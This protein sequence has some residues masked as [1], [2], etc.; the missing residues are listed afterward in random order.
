[1]LSDYHIIR[2]VGS[3]NIKDIHMFHFYGSAG[4]GRRRKSKR[5][6]KVK[7]EERCR[8][9]DLRH[10][11]FLQFSCAIRM[12]SF[13]LI[14]YLDGEKKREICTCKFS[15]NGHYMFIAC[16]GGEVGL[17]QGLN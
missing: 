2:F 17:S 7:D 12:S 15:G 16:F 10:F 8:E 14:L 13:I 5:E 9:R 3:Q 6:E 1:M 11:R 4:G